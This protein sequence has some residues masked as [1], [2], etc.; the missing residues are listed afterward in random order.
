MQTL[1]IL[2]VLLATL[3]LVIAAFGRLF[4]G[5]PAAGKTAGVALG[6]AVIGAILWAASPAAPEAPVR[7]EAPAATVPGAAHDAHEE[8]AAGRRPGPPERGRS[9]QF[10]RFAP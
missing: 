9:V 6:L 4:M 5:W 1:G 7:P 8:D 10:A 2:L 3:G